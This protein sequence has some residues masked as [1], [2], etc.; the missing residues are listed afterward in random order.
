MSFEFWKEKLF[1]GAESSEEPDQIT[2]PQNPIR[3]AV[4]QAM[5]KKLDKSNA[6]DDGVHP[7]TTVVREPTLVKESSDEWWQGV[8]LSLASLKAR[9]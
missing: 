7:E 6:D 9:K 8:V 4:E 3:E 2:F 1:K 5:I